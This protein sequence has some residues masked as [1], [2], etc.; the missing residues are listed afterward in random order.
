MRGSPVRCCLK[1]GALALL[2]I[3]SWVGSLSTQLPSQNLNEGPRSKPHNEGKGVI[4]LWGAA[5]ICPGDQTANEKV[6]LSLGQ[7]EPKGNGPVT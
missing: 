5:R 4:P 2:L 6:A 3:I 1:L 7:I